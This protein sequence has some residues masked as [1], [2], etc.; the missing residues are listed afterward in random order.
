MRHNISE[1]GTFILVKT[2]NTT[3]DTTTTT[4]GVDCREYVGMTWILTFDVI[5]AGSS[6]TAAA[7]EESPDNS[8]WTPVSGANFLAQQSIGDTDDNK[9]LIAYTDTTR[10]MQYLRFSLTSAGGA[11]ASWGMNAIGHPYRV[12]AAQTQ[13]IAFQI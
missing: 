10:R 6:V 3:Q 4:S 12:P 8:N 7:L 1:L 11:G 9:I 13:T 5:A 2:R